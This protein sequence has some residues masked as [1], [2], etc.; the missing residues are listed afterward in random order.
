[1]SRDEKSVR[2]TD[3]T[4]AHGADVLLGKRYQYRDRD[5]QEMSKTAQALGFSPKEILELERIYQR[6]AK[7]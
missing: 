1:M 4:I 7:K 5:M 3:E 6:A 2:S